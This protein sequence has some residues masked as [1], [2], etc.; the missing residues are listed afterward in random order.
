RAV[1]H[2]GDVGP[3][4]ALG[5]TR[6]SPRSRRIQ[7][8]LSDIRSLSVALVLVLT[9]VCLAPSA[10]AQPMKSS[11]SRLL[12]ETIAECRAHHEKTY[13]AVDQLLMKIEEGQR[14]NDLSKIRALLEDSQNQ[15]A[16][17]KQ[18]MAPCMNMMS[19]LDQMDTGVMQP[20]MTG[21]T[22]KSR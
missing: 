1:F 6:P 21:R 17:L 22:E 18:D 19:M 7:M 10:S 2:Q 16:D 20:G 9:N 8:L 13:H 3:Q 14:S 11:E 15:L 4:H 5:L 12:N